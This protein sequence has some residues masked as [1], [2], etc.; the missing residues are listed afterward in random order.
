MP[1]P[2]RRPVICDAALDLAATGGNHA[3]T[4]QGIDRHLELPRGS[5]SYYFRTRESLIAAA[6]DHLVAISQDSFRRRFV[7]A[8]ADAAGDPVEVITDY[9]EELL[10]DRIRDVRA[11]LALIG[12]P[13]LP[14]AVVT[15]LANCFFSASA[16]EELMRSRGAVD[17][18]A[19]ADRLLI[20]LEGIIFTGRRRRDR[21]RAVIAAAM[22]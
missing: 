11:R 1:R 6:A 18:A 12:D 21:L 14:D 3:V 8:D 22:S 9:V 15:S 19:A 5:T 7:P 17:P 13:T 16:A 10:T 20:T 4:H 2:N